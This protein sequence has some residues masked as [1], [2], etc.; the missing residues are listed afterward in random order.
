VLVERFRNKAEAD[1]RAFDVVTMSFRELAMS[2]MICFRNS[3]A[4]P[5]ETTGR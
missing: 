3:E 1:M 4:V 5:D 2:V